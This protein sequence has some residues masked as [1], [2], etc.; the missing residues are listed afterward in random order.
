MRVGALTGEIQ[1]IRKHIEWSLNRTLSDMQ[2][3]SLAK[4][5]EDSGRIASALEGLYE[6]MDKFQEKN[7]REMARK[8]E[9]VRQVPITE[10]GP[11]EL[12]FGPAIPPTGFSGTPDTPNMGGAAS[13]LLQPPLAPPQPPPAM[14]AATFVGCRHGP[15]KPLRCTRSTWKYP[16]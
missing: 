8:M 1:K 14:P 15:E 10:K 2:K 5:S 9:A 13:G 12:E 11:R 6:G 3:E 4:S 16:L 7:L